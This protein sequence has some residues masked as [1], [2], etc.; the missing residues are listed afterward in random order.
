MQAI[1]EY[2]A[3]F[4]DHLARNPIPERDHAC[5]ADGLNAAAGRFMQNSGRSPS[6]LRSCA[7]LT[8]AAARSVSPVSPGPCPRSYQSNGWSRRA[9]SLATQ[10]HS[11]SSCEPTPPTLVDVSRGPRPLALLM[12][13]ASRLTSSRFRIIYATEEIPSVGA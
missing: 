13:R 6:R 2:V 1:V 7:T 3:A 12:N 10:A 4:H 9:S 11:V 8:A 5:S